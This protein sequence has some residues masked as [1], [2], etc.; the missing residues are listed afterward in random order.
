VLTEL[1]AP[2]TAGGSTYI[3]GWM[4]DDPPRFPEIESGNS[5]A[6]GLL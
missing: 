1:P 2:P 5:T 3:M 4:S 6:G